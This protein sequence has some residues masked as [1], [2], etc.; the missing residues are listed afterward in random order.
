MSRG[1]SPCECRAWTFPDDLGH[2]SG[3][4]KKCELDS[5]GDHEKHWRMAVLWQ[6][7]KKH[8]RSLVVYNFMLKQNL[9]QNLRPESVVIGS[10]SDVL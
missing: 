1:P 3:G 10:V 4:E 6:A 2:R 7:V 8:S 9:S 5:F